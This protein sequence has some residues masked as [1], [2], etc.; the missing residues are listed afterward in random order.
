MEHLQ[1]TRIYRALRE[2]IIEFDGAHDVHTPRELVEE[3]LG[4]I[5][6]TDKSVLVMFNLEFV[7][8]LVYT[9]NIAPDNI[10]FY[11]DHDDKSRIC[12]KL[13]VKYITTLETDMKFDVVVGNP[14]YQDGNQAIWK[15]FVDF[16]VSHADTV[17][18][19]TPRTV[20][21]G[22]QRQDQ[23]ESSTDLFLRLRPGLSRIDY[24]ADQHFRVGK[25]ICWWLWQDAPSLGHATI[26]DNHGVEHQIDLEKFNYLPYEYD[27]TIA[28]IFDKIYRYPVKMTGLASLPKS[29]RDHDSYIVLP[30]SKHLSIN[31][32]VYTADL[33]NDSRITAREMLLFRCRG[34]HADDWITS[35][36]FKFM[37]YIYGGVDGAGGGFLRKFP[38]IDIT[39]SWT[40]D[41]IYQHFGLTSVEIDYIKS[42]TSMR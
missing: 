15:K 36:L 30:K 25:K 1:Y 39:R 29:G 27:A 21:N 38:F 8:S 24:S 16:A 40:D 10:T 23:Q 12:S 4:K 7:V 19:V 18:L 42:S 20:V 17:A 13:G 28:G 33:A 6:V 22:V 26:V 11:S 34:D 35:D 37:F 31:N 5:D 3:I 9:R 41:E 14:P 2:G 32:L